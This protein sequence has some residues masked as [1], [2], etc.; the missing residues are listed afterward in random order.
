ML[1][2][3]K[4]DTT[5]CGVRRDRRNTLLRVAYKLFIDC[6]SDLNIEIRWI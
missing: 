5:I 4:Q 6:S 1:E 3:W 2:L